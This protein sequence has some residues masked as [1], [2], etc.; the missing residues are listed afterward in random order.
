MKRRPVPKKKKNSRPELDSRNRQREL[1][2]RR[3]K[4]YGAVNITL[5]DTLDEDVE[6]IEEEPESETEN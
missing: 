2:D 1:L 3:T 5:D 4:K 6:E